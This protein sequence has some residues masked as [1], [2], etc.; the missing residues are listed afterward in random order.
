[1]TQLAVTMPVVTL[2]PPRPDPDLFPVL[3]PEL[4]PSNIFW[5][6]LATALTRRRDYGSATEAQY[7]A[8]LARLL[9]V[10]MID[11]A[12]NVHVDTRSTPDH[13]SMF[14]SHTDTVHSSGGVNTVRVDG[15]FWRASKG[16]ALGA[17]DGAGNAIMAYMIDRG[18]PGYY[19]F[20]RGE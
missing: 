7:V 20:F 12:G 9:P 4:L 10:S 1:M 2:T 18:L 13:R 19:V 17:D 11:A 14:T 8:W 15:K 6:V 3:D 16:A 5:D